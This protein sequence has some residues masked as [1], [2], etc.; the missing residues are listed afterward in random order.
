LSLLK[1]QGWLAPPYSDMDLRSLSALAL[2]EEDHEEGTKRGPWIKSMLSDI[3]EYGRMV[4]AEMNAITDAARFNRS[5]RGTTLYCT[6]MPCHM[7]TKLVIASGIKK[8]V[9]VQPYTKSLSGE[10]FK[11][12]VAFEGDGSDN[13]VNFC[14]LKGVTPLGF[15]R[16]FARQTK[17]KDRIGAA[18]KW[19]KLEATPTFLTTI[20]YYIH[21]ER[22]LLSELAQV[23]L[24][25]ISAALSAATSHDQLGSKPRTEK[26]QK[27]VPTKP[28][29]TAPATAPDTAP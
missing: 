7:C 8:V 11:D 20:P 6:T 29:L 17:R 3:I 1:E 9:Y 2:Q 19:N 22:S 15:K 25:E 4:H 27:K 10:L 12:S 16:A 14:S 5:T 13:K 24:K 23:P 18:L 26:T 21:S 28:D